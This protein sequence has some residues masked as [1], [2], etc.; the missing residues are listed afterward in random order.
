MMPSV[1][2]PR[3]TSAWGPASGCELRVGQGRE[4]LVVGLA[5]PTILPIL[6]VSVFFLLDS[7]RNP[8]TPCLPFLELPLN[9]TFSGRR[10]TLTT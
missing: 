10:P 8:F 2:Q 5:L 6:P 9:V 1:L 3:A 4:V 7:W